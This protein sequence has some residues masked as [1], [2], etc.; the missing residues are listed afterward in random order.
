MNECIKEFYFGIFIKLSILMTSCLLLKF[1]LSPQ[2]CED[3]EINST[4]LCN[5]AA[6]NLFLGKS[7]AHS[8]NRRIS[9]RSLLSTHPFFFVFLRVLVCRSVKWKV[10]NHLSFSASHFLSPSIF[11][12]QKIIDRLF[13]TANRL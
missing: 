8:L 1:L 10:L 11:L 4:L 6:A 3:K 13:W 7:H 12:A 9:S 2:K 5:R